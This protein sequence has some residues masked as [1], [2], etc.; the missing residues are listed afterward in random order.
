MKVKVYV[1][2]YSTLRLNT[3]K[4]NNTVHIYLKSNNVYIMPD[5]FKCNN[6]VSLGIIM[7]VHLMLVHHEDYYTEVGGYLALYKIPDNDI[8]TEWMKTTGAK[9]MTE[10]HQHKN[11]S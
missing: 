7:E 3:I 10:L 4:F 1:T 8:A 5:H 9:N 11:S 2:L 6:V